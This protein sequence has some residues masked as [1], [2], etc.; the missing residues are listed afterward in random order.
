M[1]DSSQAPVPRG[2]FARIAAVEPAP[3]WGWNAAIVALV[4]SAVAFIGI[5]LFVTVWAG[6]EPFAFY[7]TYLVAALIMAYWVAST[8][9]S[10]ADRAAMRLNPPTSGVQVPLV[11]IVFVA[12]GFAI[13]LDLLSY[14]VTREFLPVMELAFPTN[15]I[16]LVQWILSIGVMLIAQPIGEE[17]VFRGLLF[18]LMRAKLGAW[19]GLLLNAAVYA[20]F[21]YAIY[22]AQI[23]SLDSGTITWYG[24]VLPFLQGLVIALVRAY[25]RST[26]AAIFAH[27]GFGL[28][29]LLKL[30]TLTG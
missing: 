5:S 20:L 21:H 2:L 18:P 8:R 19:L 13:A 27:A 24:L 29:A 6:T 26:R 23:G 16:P 11:L 30:F 1:T 9:R 3:P 22:T 10:P 4:L 7:L 25:T 15:A 14:G 12:V 17:L 28:F